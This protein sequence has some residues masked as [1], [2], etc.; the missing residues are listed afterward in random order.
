M[1]RVLLLFGKRESILNG[2]NAL[3]R[4]VIQIFY[5]TVTVCLL[6]GVSAKKSRQE[7]KC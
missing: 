2:I 7:V 4:Y 3:H 1:G 6:I 5:Q